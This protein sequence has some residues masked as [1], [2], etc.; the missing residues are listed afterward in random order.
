MDERKSGSIHRGDG[1]PHAQ[2]FARIVVQP[3]HVD[4]AAIAIFHVVADDP[5]LLADR[6]HLA[7]LG[8]R[9]LVIATARAA[10]ADRA[11]GHGTGDRR[12]LA[13]VALAHGVA[14]HATDHRAQHRAGGAVAALVAHH[15][16]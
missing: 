9:A 4:L 5:A 2:A 8:L 14:Q 10:V 1:N 13:P 11:T 3:R 12:R 16:L 7:A 15:L 6:V